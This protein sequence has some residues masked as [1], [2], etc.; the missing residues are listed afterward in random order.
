MEIHPVFVGLLSLIAVSCSIGEIDRIDEAGSIV[1]GSE[2]VFYVTIGDQPD[3]ETKVYADEALRIKWNA[4]DRLSIFNK[5]TYNREFRFKGESGATS[6]AIAAVGSDGTGESLA[7]IY[8]VYPYAPSTSINTS[9]TITYTLPSEQSYY[10]NSF[11][12]GAN[13][14]V[15]V[16]DDNKLRFKNAGGYLS[17]KFYGD[18]V[19]VSSITLE[20]NN[21][22]F[23]SGPCTIETSSEVPALTMSEGGSNRVTLTCDPPVTLGPTV[24]SAVQFIFVLPPVTL[25]KGFKVTVATSDDRTFVKSSGK[26]R[27]IGRSAITRMQTMAVEIEPDPSEWESAAEA[28]SNMSVGWNLGNT[29]DGNSFFI[30]NMRIEVETMGTIT[31]YETIMGQP[32]T[33]RELMHMFK[34][35][36]FSAIRVPVTWYPHMGNFKSTIRREMGSDG[37]EK[38]IWDRDSW[39]GYDVDPEWMARVREVVDYVIDEGMYCILNVAHDTGEHTAAWMKAS[40]DSYY[41]SKERIGALWTQIAEEFKYYGPKLLFES[42]NEMVDPAGTWNFSTQE[43]H[44]A[45]NQYNADFVA[46]VRATGGNNIYR[47]LVLP[48]YA[49]GYFV[50]AIEAF[51]L[52]E[53]T[54]ENHLMAAFHSYAPYDFAFGKNNHWQ[55]TYWDAKDITTLMYN[56]YH[57]MVEVKGI[58]CILD[59]FGAFSEPPEEELAKH[60]ECFVTEGA[61]YGIPCFYWMAICDGVDRSVPQWTKTTL[62]DALLNA[63]NNGNQN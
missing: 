12:V 15:S 30:D 14:M 49:A 17:F 26:K 63:W 22:E 56:V 27:V 58:P 62:K 9:G 25:A 57:N 53:D 10:E 34:E 51:S 43:A 1:P 38:G 18:G 13:A 36:G 4:D 19:S 7:K 31:D 2:E 5:K 32:L 41:E 40:W 50:E 3:A 39:T 42:F 59:E 46:K 16:T 6:G 33:T 20:S 28:V 45:M 54:A 35:A 55:F 61:K 24:S 60:A 48:T 8:A 37:I 21:G 47:N 11:G 44:G 23:L 52:P 29:L